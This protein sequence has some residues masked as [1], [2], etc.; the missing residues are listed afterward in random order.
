MADART[1]E[2]IFAQYKSR[3][4]RLALS[5]SRNEK[6]AEDISQNTFIKIIKHLDDFRNQSQLSTWI[7]KVTYNEALMYLRKR[8]RNFRLANF[9][10]SPKGMASHSL[11]VN[12]AKLPDERLLDEEFKERVE[13]AIR[14]LPI[15]YRMPLLLHH[16]EAL[17]LKNAADVLNLK[18]GSLKSRLHR[19]YLAVKSEMTHYFNDR[20]AQQPPSSATC[21]LALGFIYE[22]ASQRLA[23]QKQKA[24]RA[25]I[26]DCHSCKVFLDAYAQAIRI[27]NALTCQDPPAEL[28]EKIKSFLLKK[29]S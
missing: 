10:T 26:D 29:K 14:G 20:L 16:V 1:I 5:I 18:L 13:L 21:R 8:Y 11:F 17:P 23:P 15:K 27:T 6:D 7:Y 19:A 12:W 28:Q 3:I 24:F 9:L 2:T 4:F 25:H 22:Y